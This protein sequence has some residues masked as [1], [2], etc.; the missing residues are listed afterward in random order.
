VGEQ[1]SSGATVEQARAR[2]EAGAWSEAYDAYMRARESTALEAEDAERLGIAAYMCGLN[3]EFERTF[4]EAHR[5]Y[6]ERGDVDKAAWCSFWIGMILMTIGQLSRSQGWLARTQRH[7]DELG[8]PS[9][10]GAMLLLPQ[11][12][13]HRMS[14]QREE[15]VKIAQRMAEEGAAL[16][17][18]EPR[19]NGMALEGALRLELGDLEAGFA[20]LDEAMLVVMAGELS[21]MSTG[22]SFCDVIATASNVFELSRCREWSEALTRWCEAQES[23]VAFTGKCLVLRAEVLQMSGAWDDAFAAARFALERYRGQPMGAQGRAHYALGELLR[24]Q[25][26]DEEAEQEYRLAS[27]EGQDPQPGLA[28]LRLTQGKPDAAVAAVRRALVSAGEPLARTRLLEAAVEIFLATDDTAAAQDASRELGDLA[29]SYGTTAL[30]AMALGARGSVQLA[31][32]DPAAAHGSLREA[33]EKWQECGAPYAGA[34]ARWRMSQACRD[35]GD[36]DGADL[37]LDAATRVFEKL[38]ATAE[39]ARLNDGDTSHGARAASLDGPRTLGGYELQVRFSAGGMGE[40]WAARHKLLGRP[41]AVKLI[42]SDRLDAA[43]AAAREARARFER[44]ARAT[45][46]LSSPHSVELYDFGLTDDGAFYYVME[47]LDGVDLERLVADHGAL[48]PER[49]VHI[50]LQVCDSLS[51]AHQAGLV[52]RDIKPANIL[53][54]RRGPRRDFLKV[55]DFGLVGLRRGADDEKLTREGTV[56]GTPAYLSPEAALGGDVDGRADLYALGCVAFWL[57]TGSLVFG[58]KSPTAMIVSH[59]KDDPP[60]LGDRVTVPPALDELITRCLAKDPNDRPQSA[61]ELAERLEAIELATPWTQSRARAWWSTRD[62]VT[63]ASQLAA[64]DSTR[65]ETGMALPIAAED[66]SS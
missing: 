46:V 2:A 44:E 8:R 39:L 31:T 64:G 6:L 34:V 43:D 9:L 1:V 20:L 26:R 33:W 60:R 42:R 3:D 15:A 37:E 62:V 5:A 17:E 51:D 59:A 58:G 23:A 12:V 11:V 52:H 16:G 13:R 29:A 53:L 54:C 65:T 14:G 25:G 24:A 45:A 55:V 30:R 41:A 32:G 19:I 10:A 49:V 66:P 21:P 48:A 28:M 61:A 18:V 47:L 50:L 57:L 7:V 63:V 40:V 36:V 27:Q 38:G 56:G 35:L 4:E 22:L